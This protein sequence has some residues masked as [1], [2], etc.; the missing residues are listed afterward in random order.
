MAV[1]NLP[2]I[3][4][5]LTALMRSALGV[6]GRDFR[7]VLRRAGRRLPRPVRQAGRDLLEMERQWAVPKLRTQ[8]DPETLAV[9]VKVMRDHLLGIGRAE[10]RRAYWLGVA[11]PLAFN[12][13]VAFGIGLILMRLLGGS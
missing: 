7:S 5:D 9:R 10:R 6:G 4:E 2:D 11:A 3:L 12:L 8:I 1:P 13:L